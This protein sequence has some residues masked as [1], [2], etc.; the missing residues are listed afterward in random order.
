MYKLVSFYH[1]LDTLLLE[2]IEFQHES[3]KNL[4][5]ELVLDLEDENSNLWIL[6]SDYL[7]RFPAHI[8]YYNNVKKTALYGKVD[9]ETILEWLSNNVN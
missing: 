1:T 6:H 8:L 9:T 2:Y 5:P 3:I 7:D 4:F